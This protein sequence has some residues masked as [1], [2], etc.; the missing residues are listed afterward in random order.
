M[1]Q[2]AKL[3]GGSSRAP[4][5]IARRIG[6]GAE[7]H[8]EDRLTLRS[9]VRKVHRHYFRNDPTTAQCDEFIDALGPIAQQ[10]MIK[11]KI[12]VDGSL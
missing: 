3:L 4:A 11:A 6:F 1:A 10:K 9:V 8:Y 7:L 2:K 12:D 5:V